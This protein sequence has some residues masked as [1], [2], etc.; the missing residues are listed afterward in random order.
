MVNLDFIGQNPKKITLRICDKEYE[1]T[2][3]LSFNDLEI[4]KSRLKEK[5]VDYKAIVTE[6]MVSHSEGALNIEEVSA[7]E[8]EEIDRFINA[9]LDQEKK[10]KEIFE[11][12]KF[13]SRCKRFVLAIDETH[14]EYMKDLRRSFEG[15]NKSDLSLN[16]GFIINANQIIENSISLSQKELFSALSSSL[17]RLDEPVK[18]LLSNQKNLSESLQ[19]LFDS[20]SEQLANIRKV[21]SEQ[22]SSFS[23]S[24]KKL[25]IPILRDDERERLINSF[26]EWGELG[27]T[28][29]PKADLFLFGIENA[30]S[31][32]AYKILKKHLREEDIEDLFIG[33]R[34]LDNIRKSD[35][36]EAIDS[37][38]GKNYKACT[39]I[40]FSMIDAKL[41]RSQLDVNRN[42]RGMRP[43]GVTA[44]KNLFKRIEGKYNQESMLFT[45]LY[46]TNILSAINSTFKHGNDFEEQPKVINRNFISHGMLH[47]SVLQKDCIMLFLLLYNFTFYIESF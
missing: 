37:F 23:R 32:N 38:Y 1:L 25:D 26:K 15:I 39:L 40:I 6:V 3:F 31:R 29:P 44:A 47:R 36:E 21:F 5:N 4:I 24:I 28:P 7:F 46:K 12:L 19:P 27:W 8:D 33:L 41:I 16:K 35:L 34:Q 30:N 42:K 14:K 9:Y 45:Y 17:T 13:T 20:Y 2:V 10:L 11:S 43:T 18:M 22:I